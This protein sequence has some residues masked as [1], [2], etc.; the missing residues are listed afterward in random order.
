MTENVDPLGSP[1]YIRDLSKTVYT[2]FEQGGG[3]QP[4]TASVTGG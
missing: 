3:D 4:G 1:S 2:F